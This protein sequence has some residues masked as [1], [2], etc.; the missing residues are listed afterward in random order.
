MVPP[1]ITN[2]WEDKVVITSRFLL[3]IALILAL[4][5]TAS[6][7][8]REELRKFHVDELHK[9][10]EYVEQ[11]GREMM[12]VPL[13][14]WSTRQIDLYLYYAMSKVHLALA[15]YEYDF[16]YLPSTVEGVV[17]AGYIDEIPGNPF[18]DWK[19]MRI[20]GPDEPFHPG[21]LVYQVCPEEYYSFVLNDELIPLSYELS[22]YAPFEDYGSPVNPQPIKHNA[23]WAVI[24]AN[25]LAMV[26]MYNEPAFVTL[27]KRAELEA[28]RERNSTG[29]DTA[30][31][32][33][34]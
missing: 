34:K 6:A 16:D 9:C 30:E 33:S 17:A 11:Y 10:T 7:T 28:A 18:E 24:P 32:E 20:L 14:D 12:E 5:S 3:I 1:L 15:L 25:T 21:A 22:V 19:P 2:P 13:E 8:S 27:E 23:D 29:K 26:G 4:V 31:G